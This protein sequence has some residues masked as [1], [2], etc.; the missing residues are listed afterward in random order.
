MFTGIIEEVGEVIEINDTGDFRTIRVRGQTVLDDL[1]LG[2]SIAVN[3]VCLTARS[4]R[5]DGF[6][7]ENPSARTE[8]A[9]RQTP[10]TA[11][12]EPRRRS[13]ST[14]WPRTRIVR[15]SPVS[16]IS[17]T[18]PTSSMIPVNICSQNEIGAGVFD[19]PAS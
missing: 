12:L 18:S 10:F 16:L 5:A 2:S 9:V 14:V 19:S 8:R 4:V 11:M 17:M 7:A 3:G 13:S 1:R 15:K 6:S